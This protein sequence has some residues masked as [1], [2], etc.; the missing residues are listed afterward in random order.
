MSNK[1]QV[2][3]IRAFYE[4]TT[5][6]KLTVLYAGVVPS[7]DEPTLEI[8]V[9]NGAKALTA[10]LT[11]R[12]VLSGN[13]LMSFE[14]SEQ[15]HSVDVIRLSNFGVTPSPFNDV[16]VANNIRIVGATGSYAADHWDYKVTIDTDGSSAIGYT[17]GEHGT[18]TDLGKTTNIKKVRQFTIDSN[19]EIIVEAAYGREF[20]KQC[21]ISIEG[22]QRAS[23][24]LRLAWS[25]ANSN[26]TLQSTQLVY[27]YDT[28]QELV[29]ATIGFSITEHN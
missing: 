3:T 16:R 18:M 15:L 6:S 23:I 2:R 22:V 27:L 17:A 7:G 14:T 8:D 13:T 12:Q 1:L 4:D 29:G 24:P 26:Y 19:G 10:T 25:E 11:G 9:N 21:T 28:F 20:G 5:K